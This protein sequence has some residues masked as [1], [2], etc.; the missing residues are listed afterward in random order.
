MSAEEA[1]LQEEK[2]KKRGMPWSEDEHK[3][4][5]VGLER[6]GKGDWR[7]I[8]RQCVRTR[9]PA[10]VASHAQKYFK[11]QDDKVNGSG[12]PGQRVSIHDISSVEDSLPPRNANQRKRSRPSSN[13]A[14]DDD[15]AAADAPA[16][17]AAALPTLPPSAPL[18]PTLNQVVAL[19]EKAAACLE[20]AAPPAIAT[21]LALTT[22]LPPMAAA[23][24][25]PALA[26]VSAPVSAPRTAPQLQWAPVQ[27]LHC[28]WN[29]MTGRK[30]R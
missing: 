3:L 7:S 20:P 10:Q 19:S 18:F 16:A 9:T 28:T 17:A 21:Q 25:A 30:K 22:A 23:A 13:A 24:P 8:S 27:Q 12:R 11:R 2:D 4:F 15:D 26:P 6:F 5:L 14:A 29:T 1:A